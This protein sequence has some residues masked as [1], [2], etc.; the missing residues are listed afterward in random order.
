MLSCVCMLY[1]HIVYCL[2]FTTPLHVCTV[3]API[4]GHVWFKVSNLGIGKT[5]D[6]MDRQ[7]QKIKQTSD[8]FRQYE[9]YFKGF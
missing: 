8:N 2:L 6:Y 7:I 9:P 1:R 4:V 5:N 3:G